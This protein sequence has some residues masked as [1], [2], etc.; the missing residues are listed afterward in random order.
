ME[1]RNQQKEQ[2]TPLFIDRRKEHKVKQIIYLI[3]SEF[4]LVFF[5]F[6]CSLV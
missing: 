4:A 1:E 6:L 3:Y 5:D 2:K